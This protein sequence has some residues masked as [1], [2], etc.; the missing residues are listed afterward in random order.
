MIGKY[1]E[2]LIFDWGL[3]DYIGQKD[4]DTDLFTETNDKDP[5]LTQPRESCWNIDLPCTRKGFKKTFQH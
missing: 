2:V 5:D 1:G 3:A 4:L